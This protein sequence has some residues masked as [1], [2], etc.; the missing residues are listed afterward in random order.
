MIPKV[1]HYCWFGGN[2]LNDMAKKCIESWKKYCPDYEIVEW[3][4]SN[5][6]IGT[7][8]DY[9]KEAYEAKKWAFVS[10]YVRLW[11]IYNY[12]GIYLDVDVELIKSID[13]LRKNKAFFGFEDDNNIATGV[14]FG[15]EKDNDVVKELINDYN[16][17]HFKN[18]DGKFDLTPC[19]SR[20]TRIFKK[21]GFEGNGKKQIVNGNVVY[22]K[23]YFCPKDYNTNILNIT[24]NTVSIHHFIASW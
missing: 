10:D 2:P 9:V 24:E 21:W 22:P 7:S 11:A 19:P 5:F 16:N 8:C 18:S 20:N 14:G 1:I 17:I 15:A 12:G 23:D 3:N 13:F 6:D 4:E